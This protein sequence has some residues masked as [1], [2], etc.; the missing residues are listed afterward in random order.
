[1]TFTGNYSFTDANAHGIPDAYVVERFGGVDPPRTR[2]T[3][4]DRD[5][6]SDWVEFVA[7]TEPNNPPPPFRL[8]P[9]GS[10]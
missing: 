5:G 3:D 8:I 6:M 10:G 9:R 1:M 2:F 7:G 4:T